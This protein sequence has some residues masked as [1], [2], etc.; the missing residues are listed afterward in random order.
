MKKN[1]LLIK[2][3]DFIVDFRYLFLIIFI[4]LL[5]ICG[6]NLNNIKVNNDITSYLPNDTETKDGLALMEQEFGQLNELQLLVM[7]I[8]YEEALK[9]VEELREI[10][11]VK[12]INFINNENYYKD[13]KA[14]FIIELDEVSDNERNE[15]VTKIKESISSKE[16]YLYIENNSEVVGGMTLIL[17]LVISVIVLVLLVTSKSYFDIVIAF[18]IFGVSILLNMGSNFLLKEISYITK[19]IAVVLQLGLSLD[20]LIIFLNHYMKEIKD[21]NEIDLAVKKTVSKSIPEVLASSLTT[22]AGLMSLVFM[23]LKIGGDIGIVMSKGIICSMLTVILL[24]PCLLLIFNKT[25]T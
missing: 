21:N 24:L 3:G 2:L 19:S 17:C 6:I 8:H 10:N 15:V 7:N 11:H 13:E 1:K 20:Y 16:H 25:Y 14:L 5:I 4:S 9:K 23:Q 18:I 12:K 22:I